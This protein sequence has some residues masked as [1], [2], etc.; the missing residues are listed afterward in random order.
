VGDARANNRFTY[1]DLNHFAECRDR[2]SV[3]NLDRLAVGIADAPKLHHASLKFCCERS[4][5]S[6]V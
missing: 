2:R 3:L 4:D 1:R 5:K 6:H